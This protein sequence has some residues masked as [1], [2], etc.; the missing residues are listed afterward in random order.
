MK[1]VLP[2]FPSPN[3]S[4][5]LPPARAPPTALFFRGAL[6]SLPRPP[7]PPPGGR[8]PSMV[9]GS[10]KR[11]EGKEKERERITVAERAGTRNRWV[12]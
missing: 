11:G 3:T 12:F 10:S 7:S 5:G 2:S 9:L 8:P 1:V 6:P 4:R